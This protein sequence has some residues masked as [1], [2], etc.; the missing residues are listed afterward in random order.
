MEGTGTEA[1]VP[2]LSHQLTWPSRRG[3]NRMNRFFLFQKGILYSA[4]WGFSM[5]WKRFREFQV[6]WLT[7]NRNGN[8]NKKRNGTQLSTDWTHMG[9]TAYWISTTCTA[10]KTPGAEMSQN[11]LFPF[12]RLFPRSSSDKLTNGREA[13]PSLPISNCGRFP[14]CSSCLFYFS[15]PI[16]TLGETR[17]QQTRN[18]LLLQTIGTFFKN[19]ILLIIVR[20]RDI[21][22]SSPYWA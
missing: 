5:S 7:G 18:T 20:C 19:Q 17:Q 2:K 16:E 6:F 3:E 12:Q 21:F 13:L 14:F 11:S 9:V 10:V 15:H 8:G 4:V 1:I 22:F